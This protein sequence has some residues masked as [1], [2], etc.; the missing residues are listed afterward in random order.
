VSSFSRTR[1]LAG[2][3]VDQDVSDG[4]EPH[5]QL[6]VGPAKVRISLTEAACSSRS[7]RSGASFEAKV[8]TSPAASA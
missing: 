6:A 3:Y 7:D 1:G 4:D 5:G 2:E 8:C